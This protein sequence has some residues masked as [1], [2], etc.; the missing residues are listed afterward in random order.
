MNEKRRKKKERKRKMEKKK[1][2]NKEKIGNKL[3]IVHATLIDLI[4]FR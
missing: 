4:A 2:K 3:I 1:K